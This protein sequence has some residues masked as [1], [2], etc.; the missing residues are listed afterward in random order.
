MIPA[1]S[2]ECELCRDSGVVARFTRSGGYKCAGPFP[3]D[4]RGCYEDLC[5]CPE[6]VKAR[7]E[8]RLHD[9]AL[10]KRDKAG[11]A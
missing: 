4:A 3:D 11:A 6:G 9:A 2:Y 10:A 5:D 7:R 8:E 1:K